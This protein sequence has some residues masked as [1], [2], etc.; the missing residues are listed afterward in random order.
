MLTRN[1]FVGIYHFNT[2]ILF[3]SLGIITIEKEND[4]FS[5]NKLY[6]GNKLRVV[7]VSC[8]LYFLGSVTSGA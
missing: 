4:F 6:R 5:L 2:R 1:K 3:L 7:Y 8:L